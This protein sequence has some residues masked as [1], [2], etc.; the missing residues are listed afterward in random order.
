MSSTTYVTIGWGSRIGA[1]DRNNAE[2]SV[3]PATAAILERMEQLFINIKE[4]GGSVVRSANGEPHEYLVER[5]PTHVRTVVTET[6][7]KKSAA[8]LERLQESGKQ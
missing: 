5:D 4:A 3:H 8:A 6:A 7:I 1:R 2:H